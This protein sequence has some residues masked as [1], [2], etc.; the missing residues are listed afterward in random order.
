MKF[1]EFLE[2]LEVNLS[3]Y[4]TFMQKALAFQSSKNAKRAPKS[5]WNEARVEKAAYEMWKASM[6]TLFNKIKCEVRSDQPSV[7]ISFMEK[8]HIFDI[9]NDGIAEMDFS[10]DAI[11]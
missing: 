1:K 5:R 11:A 4:H 9:L 3:S 10:E 8:N 2:Y 6:D 7:W